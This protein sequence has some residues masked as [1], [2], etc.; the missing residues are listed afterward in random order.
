MHVYQNTFLRDTPVARDYFLFGL[1]TSGMK[2]SERDVFNN[3]FIQSGKVP[4]AV[5]G[6]KQ[7]EN[8]H[9]GGNILWGVKD[10]PEMKIDPF[11][12]FRASP[13]FVASK[14]RYEAGWTTQDRV[15]DPKFVRP[16]GAQ[17]A[18]V[19]LRLQADSPAV[20]TG[21]PVPAEWPDPL[22]A[23]DKDAPDVGAIPL[24][25]EA[26]GVGVDGRIPLFGDGKM[27]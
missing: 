18:P 22:R 11:A 25:A 16:P 13:L 5:F 2:N 23:A 19:D 7:A 14:E 6:M 21:Q 27:P 26:W 20:N 8:I 17:A 4:G 3:F 24:G 12:K 15:I 10:G 1:G 9:E